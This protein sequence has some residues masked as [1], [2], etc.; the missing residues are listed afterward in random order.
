MIHASKNEQDIL[1]GQVTILKPK[2]AIQPILPPTIRAAVHQWMTEI[3]AEKELEALGVG[4]RRSAL[5]SE[6]PGCG[7]TTLAHHLAA[8][9]GFDLYVVNADTLNSRYVSATSNNIGDLFRHMQ[10]LEHETVLFFDEFDTLAATRLA[11]E[12]ALG[13]QADRN[14]TVN[15]L[16]QRIET[17]KGILIAATNVSDQID[18]A[19]WRRFGLQ[20]TIPTPGPDERYAIITL[21]AAPLK[22]DA[23]LVEFLADVT[24]GASPSLIRQL[25]EGLK[26]DTI[27]APRLNLNPALE[28]ALARIRAT[29]R[30]HESY[31]I[32]PPLWDDSQFPAMRAEI[33]KF[34]WPPSKNG[35][36]P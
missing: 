34:P 17:Y 33:S 18:P 20:M 16:L 8:R 13:G 10:G 4:P 6:P 32:L 2:D 30:P 5:L 9:L 14:H 29:T 3:R 31:G 1:G 35:D 15:A 22:F 25:I 26:R 21:Y 11:A 24:E 19:I 27:L 23:D 12:S 7:K 28:H 36:A